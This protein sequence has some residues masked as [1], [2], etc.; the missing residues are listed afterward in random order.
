[1][2]TISE[3]SAVAAMV[4]VL[5]LLIFLAY[6][7]SGVNKR[8]ISFVAI[9]AVGPSLVGLIYAAFAKDGVAYLFVL[10]LLTML[11]NAKLLESKFGST[12][13]IG[14]GVKYRLLKDIALVSV[15]LSGL[16]V[17]FA[18]GFPAIGQIGEGYVCL[19]LSGFVLSLALAFDEKLVGPFKA[20]HLIIFVILVSLAELASAYGVFTISSWYMRSD[21]SL[22]LAF[23]PGLMKSLVLARLLV[24]KKWQQKLDQIGWLVSPTY[25]DILLI[26]LQVGALVANVCFGILILI[27][28]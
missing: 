18:W 14:V 20:L 24:V 2:F 16:I 12:L 4:G 3:F 15:L 1:M 27:R 28:A 8:A 19:L 21:L 13:F 17:V 25:G 23:I 6:L 22:V 5:Y 7:A 9:V 11:A 26:V 10:T